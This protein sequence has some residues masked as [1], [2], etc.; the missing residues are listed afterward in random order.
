M[1]C[2]RHMY[3]FSQKIVQVVEFLFN[4]SVDA[5]EWLAKCAMLTFAGLV[6]NYLAITKIINVYFNL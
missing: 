1:Q 5:I 4:V 6:E 3:T 2:Q